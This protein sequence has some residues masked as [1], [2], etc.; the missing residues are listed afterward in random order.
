MSTNDMKKES[1]IVREVCDY[2]KERGIFF[3]RSN[4][5][6]VFG[7]SLPKYT[8]KGLP[9]IFAIIRGHCIGI[10]VKRPTGEDGDRERNGRKVR[11]GKLSPFQAEFGT[12]LRHYAGPGAKS[13]AIPGSGIHQRYRVL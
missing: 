5:I 3:W 12:K 8:P 1:V 2:L 4:N 10:E 7:R 13:A 6:P 9:D 11:G